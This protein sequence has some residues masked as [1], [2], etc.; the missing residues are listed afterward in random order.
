[1]PARIF[2]L[3]LIG[4]RL[5]SVPAFTTEYCGNVTAEKSRD[6]NI[7]TQPNPATGGWRLSFEIPRQR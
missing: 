1:M 5:K 6:Q 4:E 3:D 7:V 2:V